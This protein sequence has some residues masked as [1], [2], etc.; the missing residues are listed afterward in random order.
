MSDLAVFRAVETGPIAWRP[1]APPFPASK[2]IADALATH[3]IQ[4]AAS[5]EKPPHPIR[6]ITMGEPGGASSP[7]AIAARTASAA[8]SA[9]ASE[10]A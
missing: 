3:P 4:P 1:C 8:A 7:S 10:A 9:S 6:A 5:P 2:R